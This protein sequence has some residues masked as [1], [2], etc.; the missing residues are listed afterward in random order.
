[1]RQY[2]RRMERCDDDDCEGLV[3]RVVVLTSSSSDLDPHSS[4]AA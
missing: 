3:L 2:F 1:M 4:P